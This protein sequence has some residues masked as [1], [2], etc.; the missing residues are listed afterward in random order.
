MSDEFSI[1]GN[2]GRRTPNAAGSDPGATEWDLNKAAPER[3]R[4]TGTQ[5]RTQRDAAATGNRTGSRQH[6]AVPGPDG[7]RGGGTQRPARHR[8]TPAAAWLLAPPHHGWR[9]RLSF[10]LV[11]GVIAF[12]T[13]ENEWTAV[14]TLIKRD[15][16]DEFAIGGGKAFKPQQY[17]L[18]TL[19]DTLKLP[20]S[21]DKVI[22]R[23]EL[24]M[25][26]TDSPGLSTSSSVMNPRSCTSSST[27]RIRRPPP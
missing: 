16:G 4:S 2:R 22:E 20:S 6:G 8:Y 18:K 26:R 21:L 24:D 17:N 27:G 5:P 13:I 15:T 7:R 9:N 23:A 25:K 3:S 14:A 12:T 10:I 19:L 11:F 1:D